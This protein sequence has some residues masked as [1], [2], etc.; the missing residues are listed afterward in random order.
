MPKKPKPENARNPLRVLRE[1]LSERGKKE[2]I[3]QSE[4]SVLIDVPATSIKAIEAGQRGLRPGVIQRVLMGAGAR[5]DGKAWACAFKWIEKENKWDW[6]AEKAPFTYSVFSQ[7]RKDRERRPAN[8]IN[9]IVALDMK[10][11]QLFV[12][13]P[14]SKWWSLALRYNEFV[15]EC[16]N[17]YGADELRAI[18]DNESRAA[19]AQSFEEFL[20]RYQ[21]HL[22][23]MKKTKEKPA[24]SRGS[25]L[26]GPH[27]DALEIRQ[28]KQISC[29]NSTALFHPNRTSKAKTNSPR[30]SERPVLK[31]R[32]YDT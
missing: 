22:A 7:F 17:D 21:Q 30:K 5:W 14:D 10:L 32:I 12:I 29:Q 24:K 15:E 13:I 9:Q 26:I 27:F 6:S 23:E 4:L 11:T 18:Y 2:P 1:L 28:R 8:A 20:Q 16:W 25:R 3:T 19:R 31:F